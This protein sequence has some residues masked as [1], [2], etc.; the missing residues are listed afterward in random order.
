[1]LFMNPKYASAAAAPY[2]TTP[3]GHVM[4]WTDALRNS[5]NA[6]YTSIRN[7]TYANHNQPYCT[8]EDG[9]H[10]IAFIEA[11]LKSVQENRWVNIEKDVIK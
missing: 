1:V 3:A 11:C 9:W 6:F 10:T 7:R 2:I 8:F 5:V 4:G